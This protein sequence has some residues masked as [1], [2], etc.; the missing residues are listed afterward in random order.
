MRALEPRLRSIAD[1]IVSTLA[2]GITVDAVGAIGYPFAARAQAE[3]LSAGERNLP[4]SLTNAHG[5]GW[6]VAPDYSRS[7]SMISIMRDDSVART[8]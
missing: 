7:R 6:C 4:D 3:W 5:A 8:A 1:E 2:P